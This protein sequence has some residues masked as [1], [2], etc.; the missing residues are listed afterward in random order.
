MKAMSRV[1]AA[2]TL[3]VAL[4]VIADEL[5]GI[6]AAADKGE[7][8]VTHE[9]RAEPAVALTASSFDLPNIDQREVLNLLSR[10]LAQGCSIEATDSQGTS[11]VNVAVLTAEPELLR[12]LL[13][14][15]ADPAVRISHS[16]PW[17]NGK[18]SLEFAQLLDKVK[19]S[20]RR[21]QIVEMLSSR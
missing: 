4:D 13:E 7:C 20:P 6:R 19:P 9:G 10:F 11:P 2:M 3:L 12:F 5:A 17:A 15:G 8:T 16:R 1:A 21:K 14:A 18:N